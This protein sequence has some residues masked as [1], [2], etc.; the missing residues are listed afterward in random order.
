MRACQPGTPPRLEARDDRFVKVER[1][2][3][4]NPVDR[5]GRAVA[6]AAILCRPEQSVVLPEEPS[7]AS[8]GPHV[9]LDWIPAMSCPWPERCRA[10]K[11]VEL[12]VM[13]CGGVRGHAGKQPPAVI[14]HH[15]GRIYGTDAVEQH[16]F[17]GPLVRKPRRRQNLHS[18]L[19]GA[20][21]HHEPLP[22]P[23]E[24]ERIRQVARPL[25]DLHRRIES[26]VP[27]HS[28]HGN[29]AGSSCV[30]VPLRGRRDSPLHP[31]RETGRPMMCPAAGV[32]P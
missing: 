22:A 10:M 32:V 6:A 20:F 24:H 27:R 23:L 26:A 3:P 4:V 14:H 8:R 5:R 12:I 17:P 16:F 9:G 2:Q 15:Q 7:R 13:A 19:A 29:L 21:G 31:P 30:V 25:D 18:R 11:R 1:G 28:R